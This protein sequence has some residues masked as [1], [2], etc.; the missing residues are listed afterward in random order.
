MIEFTCC[1]ACKEK[2]ADFFFFPPPTFI[3]WC[4]VKIIEAKGSP[5]C[6]AYEKEHLPFYLNP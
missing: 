4:I 1:E 6:F 3:C 2:Q 5:V